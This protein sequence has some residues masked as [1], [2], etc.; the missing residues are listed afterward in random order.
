MK[1]METSPSGCVHGPFG[2]D[3]SD[4]D[5]TMAQYEWSAPVGVRVRV[6][7]FARPKAPVRAWIT[8]AICRHCPFL[9]H[10]RMHGR[11]RETGLESP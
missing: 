2:G 4:C 10:W 9:M 3:V 5:E 11:S 6:R 7:A 8:D 1:N